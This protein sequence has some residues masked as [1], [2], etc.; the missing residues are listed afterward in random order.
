M[1]KPD[2]QKQVVK[3]GG[4]IKPKALPRGTPHSVCFRRCTSNQTK[5]NGM[6]LMGQIRKTRDFPPL[7]L[8]TNFHYQGKGPM[9]CPFAMGLKAKGAS[10]GGIGV[11]EMGGMS[12]KHTNKGGGSRLRRQGRLHRAGEKRR[13]TRVA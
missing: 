10:W 4:G 7:E 11:L 13:A 1:R 2:M 6:Y 12:T 3:G 8:S 9:H 5:N